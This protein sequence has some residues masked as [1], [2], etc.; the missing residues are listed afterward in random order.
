M[1]A[2]LPPVQVQP[3][4]L[5]SHS[6]QHHGPVLLVVTSNL[7]EDFYVPQRPLIL[8]PTSKSAPRTITRHST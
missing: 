8:S 4:N 1:F 7:D 5:S 6:G 2:I 3:G